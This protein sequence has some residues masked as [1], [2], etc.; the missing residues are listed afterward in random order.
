MPETVAPEA[1]VSTCFAVEDDDPGE[2][3]R[4]IDFERDRVRSATV[5]ERREPP[6]WYAACSQFKPTFEFVDDTDRHLWFAISLVVASE[7]LIA[8]PFTVSN[9]RITVVKQPG[10]NERI[11]IVEDGE[12]VFGLH[13]GGPGRVA[14][15]EVD[16]EPVGVLEVT[17]CGTIMQERLRFNGELVLETNTTGTLDTGYTVANLHSTRFDNWDCADTSEGS[18]V[19]W[20]AMRAQD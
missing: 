4:T 5:A 18:A 3:P 7:V 8:P 9:A 16:A 1:R 20:I 6:A 19:M 12:L 10:W 13:R 17:R 14:N 2:P 11:E 15:I